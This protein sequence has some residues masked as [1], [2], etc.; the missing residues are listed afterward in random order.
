LVLHTSHIIHGSSYPTSTV[1][2]AQVVVTRCDI[3]VQL[4]LLLVLATVHKEC[5]PLT[6]GRRY[7]IETMIL[8]AHAI[9][10]SLQLTI[11]LTCIVE[12]KIVV[13]R[14]KL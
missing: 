6:L 11:L 4:L 12:E 10:R 3:L 13:A 2:D 8:S 14:V 9:L 1:D 5:I 7:F